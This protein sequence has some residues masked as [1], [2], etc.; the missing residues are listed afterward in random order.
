MNEWTSVYNELPKPFEVVWIFWRDREVLLGCHTYEH[1]EGE[2]NEGWYS[3]EDEKCRWTHW[4]QRVCAS[5]LDG[6]KEPGK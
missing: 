4:W 1:G 2:P 5:N 3:F 6:P